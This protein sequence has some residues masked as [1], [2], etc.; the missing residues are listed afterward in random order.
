MY[1]SKGITNA[2]VELMSKTAQRARSTN[3]QEHYHISQI[4]R[5]RHTPCR[6][7][8]RRCWAQCQ[9]T[10]DDQWASVHLYTLIYTLTLAQLHGLRPISGPG[11]LKRHALVRSPG[12]LPCFWALL[13]VNTA[14]FYSFPMLLYT[15]ISLTKMKELYL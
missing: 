2:T 3:R 6:P 11:L 9:V 8:R 13:S 7:C 1:I 12:L 5:K 4:E 10:D 14:R 15:I